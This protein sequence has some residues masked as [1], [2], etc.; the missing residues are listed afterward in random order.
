MYS[1]TFEHAEATSESSHNNGGFSS[2]KREAYDV[3]GKGK[4]N[5]A[6]DY[7][8]PVEEELGERNSNELYEID[9]FLELE[10]RDPD[11][12]KGLNRIEDEE[13]ESEI[14]STTHW[15]ETREGAQTH[16]ESDEEEYDEAI[17]PTR[18]PY[19]STKIAE[20][21]IVAIEQGS[22]RSH[23]HAHLVPAALGLMELGSEG[24]RKEFAR[25]ILREKHAEE[26]KTQ[27]L[28]NSAAQV[29][30]GVSE[31]NEA[32][33]AAQR[34]LRESMLREARMEVAQTNESKRQRYADLKVKIIRGKKQ[35]FEA[36]K[37]AEI[38]RLEQQI[39]EHKNNIA[40]SIKTVEGVMEARKK[41]KRILDDLLRSVQRAAAVYNETERDRG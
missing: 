3:D 22:T 9:D 12:M 16:E 2:S 17:K 4:T 5:G 7:E 41:G 8:W 24:P 38:Q 29:I 11:Q 26:T 6:K 36:E 39:S 21:L 30:K 15:G 14:R 18:K 23:T 13:H 25:H 31:A 20:G 32:A 35:E 37:A 10:R 1:D 40:S 27:N 28:Y 34:E 19:N 33:S